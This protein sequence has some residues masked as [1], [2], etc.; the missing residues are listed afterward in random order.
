LTTSSVDDRQ[1]R[2]SLSRTPHLAVTINGEMEDMESL[3][4]DSNGDPDISLPLNADGL[5][6]IEAVNGSRNIEELTQF[7]SASGVGK[8]DRLCEQ[9]RNLFEKLYWF[10]KVVFQTFEWQ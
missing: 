5:R 6:L 3:T 4:M 10:D 8:L 9:A 7:I 1:V 2:R